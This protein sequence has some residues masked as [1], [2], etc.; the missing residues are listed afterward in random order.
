[1]LY[2]WPARKHWEKRLREGPGECRRVTFLCETGTQV[3]KQELEWSST[4]WKD[5]S[6]WAPLPGTLA[7]G[8][9]PHI[10]GFIMG[11]SQMGK[12]TTIRSRTICFVDVATSGEYVQKSSERA[13]SAVDEAQSH[14]R[15]ACV[16]NKED[17]PEPWSSRM[18]E[19][20]QTHWL[21]CWPCDRV[22]VNKQDAGDPKLP[23]PL[24][25]ITTA[26]K[27]AVLFP[28]L[29]PMEGMLA[30]LVLSL[31]ER[32]GVAGDIKPSRKYSCLITMLEMLVSDY[33]K[34]TWNCKGKI[35]IR[36]VLFMLFDLL[37]KPHL[38]FPHL[39][40]K[41]AFFKLTLTLQLMLEY[42]PIKVSCRAP[43]T[44]SSLIF[45]DRK[46]PIKWQSA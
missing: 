33:L 14:S 18:S 29:S 30:K 6:V 15:W 43:N 37:C 39:W 44:V 22:S 31:L 28:S 24:P 12:I 23:A 45:F 36:I 10:Y 38:F 16:T 35:N 46:R 17:R 7:I 1:M 32:E 8:P 20:L 5:D 21:S 13:C 2:Q 40:R 9:S 4:K 41:W 42:V 27:C 34:H 3:G 19:T 26:W 11:R 25:S